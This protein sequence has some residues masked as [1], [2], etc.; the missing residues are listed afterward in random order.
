M[1]YMSCL[2]RKPSFTG[3]HQ[4]K[5]IS[6]AP[7]NTTWTGPHQSLPKTLPVRGC[8]CPS[9]RSCLA[10]K[11][12]MGSLGPKGSQEKRRAWDFNEGKVRGGGYQIDRPYPRS[13]SREVR[14]R[15]P[16]FSVIYFSRGTLP[17]KG[18]KGSTQRPSI[19]FPFGC[20][21]PPM[22]EHEE[23]VDLGFATATSNHPSPHPRLFV[24]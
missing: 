7:L 6:R 13:S 10:R 17:K 22:E 4:T 1:R 23:L 15:V 24:A 21:I 11:G 16:L 9:F 18:S 19:Q 12:G 8:S 14:I 2:G 5:R 20:E 3:T